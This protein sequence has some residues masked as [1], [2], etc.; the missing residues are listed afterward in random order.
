MISPEQLSRHPLFA[1]TN[2]VVL[3]RALEQGAYERAFGYG[4]PVSAG[5]AALGLLLVGRAQVTK[6]AGQAALRMSELG[7]GSLLGAAALFT[8]SGQPTEITALSA[9]QVLFFPQSVF[10]AMLEADFGLT[11]R[12]LSYLAARIRFLTDRIKSIACP[13]AADKLL[14]HLAQCADEAGQ[15]R[16]PGGMDALAQTLGMGRATL[17]RALKALEEAGH[18][19]REGRAIYFLHE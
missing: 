6:T 16:A 13:T 12:Y 7:P 3:R 10:T 5:E 19:R 18:I 4:E 2:P 17:Y 8:R 1:G 9:C 11:K 15:V 14:C